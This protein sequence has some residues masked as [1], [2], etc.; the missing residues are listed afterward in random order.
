MSRT[1]LN[2]RKVSTNNQPDIHNKKSKIYKKR[3]NW[4]SLSNKKTSTSKDKLSANRS[5]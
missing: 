4:D 3:Y 1:D 5:N 2:N